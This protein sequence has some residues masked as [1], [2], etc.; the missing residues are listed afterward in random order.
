MSCVAPPAAADATERAL[1]PVGVGDAV[2]TC[3]GAVVI[4]VQND[5]PALEDEPFGQAVHELAPAAE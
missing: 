4:T 1:P 5:E 3:V 2:G